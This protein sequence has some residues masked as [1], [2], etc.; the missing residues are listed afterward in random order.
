M[1]TNKVLPA[2]EMQDCDSEQWNCCREELEQPVKWFKSP[3]LYVECY[4]Y[5]RIFE[6][7]NQTAKLGSLDPF[8]HKKKQA[9]DHSLGT[10]RAVGQHLLLH[11]DSVSRDVFRELVEVCLWGNRNDLSISA[12]QTDSQV[13]NV[14]QDLDQ[15]RPR[16]LVNDTE[17]L[18]HH[19]TS[20]DG[21][22][23]N[24]SW[25]MDNTGL[26]AM[27]DLCLADYLTRHGLARSIRFH[28][29]R[30]PWFV[31]DVTRADVTLMLQW[32]AAD[33]EASSPLKTLAERWTKYFETQ[34]WTVVADPFWTLPSPY[35]HMKASDSQLYGQ[36]SSSSLIVFKVPNPVK[37]ATWSTFTLN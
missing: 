18:W 20:R 17:R 11:Q 31:S 8:S 32:M 16:I 29:K 21:E 6:T 15:L 36:L 35:C 1:Q 37:P 28:V 9:F 10:V 4:M 7:L 22:E 19:L 26:E 5:R 2:L 34:Q 3:W 33:A 23:R 24:V 30:M 13:A 14:V 12:G 25:V 27:A